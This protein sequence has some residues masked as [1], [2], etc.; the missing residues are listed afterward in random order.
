MKKLVLAFLALATAALPARPA[1]PEFSVELFSNRVVKALTL[2]ATEQSVNICGAKTDGP[3]L[4]AAAHKEN[5]LPRRSP[6]PL[7]PRGGGPELHASHGRFHRP[8][9]YNSHI[10]QGE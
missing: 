1:S 6:C 7:P 2:E 4:G 3:C 8:V 10:R 5:F 9:S